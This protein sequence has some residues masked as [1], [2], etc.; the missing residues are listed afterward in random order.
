GGERDDLAD[1]GGEATGQLAGVDAAKAPAAGPPAPAWPLRG[2][3]EPVDH[4]RG[5]LGGGA[6]VAAEVPAVRV[7]AALAQEAA[8]RAGGE[9]ARPETRKGGG[10]GAGGR[11]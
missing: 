11:E 1:D 9:G 2:G 7:V 5:G 4:G 8:E 10:G 6:A 3:V